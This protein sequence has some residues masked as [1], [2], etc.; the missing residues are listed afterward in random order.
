MKPE[1]AYEKLIN[2]SRQETVLAS[3]NDLLE[4]DEEVRMPSKG[5][6]HRAVQMALLAGLTHDRATDPRY[7]ELLSQVEA[8][9]LVSD[10]ESPAAVNVR[11]L[12]RG[13]DK[14][15]RMPRALVEE[16]ARVTT[17]ASRAWEQARRK[18][19][20]KSAAPWLDKVFAI[21]REEADASGHNGNRYDALLD[22]YEPGMTSDQLAALL[23]QVRDGVLPLIDSCR[24]RQSSPSSFSLRGRRF[25]LDRQRSLS[26]DIARAVGFDFDAGRID[27]GQNPFCTEIGPGDVR[28]VLRF[29][30]NDLMRGVFTLL[31]ELGH[32]LYDQGLDAAH[33][34]TPMGSS[35]SAA[36]HESQ[37]RLWE[38]F[39]GRSAGFWRYFY[40]Q[41]QNAFAR[42][43][44]DVPLETFRQIINRVEP[45]DIRVEADEV[46][47]N[48]HI[49]I[50]VELER[51]LLSGDLVAADL[52]GAWSELY[53]RYLGVTPADD[54]SGCLQDSH[55]AEGLIGYFPTYTLGNV[56]AAQIYETAARDLGSIDDAFA[57]GNFTELREWLRENIHR[58]GMR[59]RSDEIIERITGRPADPRVLIRSLSQR[60][61]LRTT[62]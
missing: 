53:Q 58:H 49:L 28:V 37:S 14:E 51:A 57:R 21:A 7:G 4:W 39:V 59:Y 16:S 29:Y 46:T 10:P 17:L 52:P 61:A 35:T 1:E 12:R 11:E 13:Y 36:F 48:I 24:D 15:C 23:T 18:N 27:T 55:W 42:Q 43:L 9:S 33:Y 6:K 3:C 22:D 62:H 60:Y 20:Y 54:R 34:G 2:L 50:R 41:L 31:H 25:A 45:G 30:A 44:R 38:N 56:Y 26:Q 8:S 32:A 19:D 47:Y 40:P 5:L